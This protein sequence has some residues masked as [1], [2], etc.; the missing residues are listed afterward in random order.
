MDSQL[1]QALQATSSFASPRAFAKQPAMTVLRA[2][3]LLGQQQ[4]VHGQ[5]ARGYGEHEAGRHC[6][7]ERQLDPP[8]G[9]RSRREPIT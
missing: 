2:E 7:P 8:L 5:M 9:M 3:G 4:W 1:Y 6:P